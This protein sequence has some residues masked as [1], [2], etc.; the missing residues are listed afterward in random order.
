MLN[1]NTIIEFASKQTEFILVTVG[2][3]KG[4]SPRE[5]GAKMLVTDHQVI[6]TIGGGN[7]EFFA[8]EHAKQCLI[9]S[10]ENEVSQ[11]TTSL[12]P[13]YDQCCG[14]VVQLIFERIDPQ[15]STWLKELT[16]Y[17]NQKQTNQA[18]LVT[19]TQKNIRF[20]KTFEHSHQCGT[21]PK[22][23]CEKEILQEP[24]H[25]QAI[26]IVIFGT[27]HVGKAIINQL[28][29]LN[30]EITC[31]DSR[32]EQMPTIDACNVQSIHS[33]N[34]N[35]YVNEAHDGVYFLVLTHSHT[36]D[37]EIS[38]AILKRNKHHYFG[39][40]GSKT[41]KIRFQRQLKASGITEKQLN[42]MT[43][44]IGLPSIKGKTPGVIA[45]SVVAQ[46]LQIQSQ[47]LSTN[48]SIEQPKHKRIHHV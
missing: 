16:E 26:P 38:E 8:I 39:L 12:T 29:H 13:S 32:E 46:I 4:S 34:W 6:G 10:A 35:K 28:H 2:M 15:T 30:V 41:K 3:V 21:E 22:A 24:L 36:L 43:C 40:I 20:F 17:Y 45:A 9:S 7:L 11:H 27:G 5:T 14:G 18:W 47:S 42:Q 25:N 19:D 31:I 44:P 23:L 48:D 33:K 1:W 37:Y